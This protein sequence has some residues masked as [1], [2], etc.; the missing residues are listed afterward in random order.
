MRRPLYLAAAARHDIERLHDWLF[1]KNANA[2]LRLIAVLDQ[3][4]QRLGDFPE[5][6]RLIDGGLRELIVPFGGANYVIRYEVDPDGVFISRI[7][8]SLEDR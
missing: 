3:H 1:E 8:H 6:G 7:W 4:L 5:R 2:A